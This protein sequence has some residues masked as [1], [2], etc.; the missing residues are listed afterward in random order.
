MFFRALV[1]LSL[2][3][4]AAAARPQVNVLGM[5]R[6]QKLLVEIHNPSGHQLAIDA[7]DWKLIAAGHSVEAG[8]LK[9]SRSVPPG[10]STILELPIEAR[11]VGTW[12]LEGS[13]RDA[14]HASWQVSVQ[15]RFQ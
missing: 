13:L 5:A 15:G 4:C 7:F 6:G 2:V 14:E 12:R 3:A 11:P 1:V 8:T 9:V 10:G